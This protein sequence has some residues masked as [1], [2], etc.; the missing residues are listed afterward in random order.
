MSAPSI[1]DTQLWAHGDSDS[2]VLGVHGNCSSRGIH[3]RLVLVLLLLLQQLLS[4][5]SIPTTPFCCGTL[6]VLHTAP[7]GECPEML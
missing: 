4:R 3:E 1:V 5:G 7:H 2:V 6:L